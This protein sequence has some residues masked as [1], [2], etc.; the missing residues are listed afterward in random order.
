M[1]GRIDKRR[2]LI[3][4]ALILT[5]AGG[6]AIQFHVA[7]SGRNAETALPQ[8]GNETG[9]ARAIADPHAM[10]VQQRFE[11]AVALL[12]AGHFE[13]AIA[14]LREVLAIKPGLPEAHINMGYALLGMGNSSAAASHFETASDLRPS[15]YNAYYGL[16]LAE[17]DN[18]NETKALAAM[19]AFA[20]LADQGDRHLPRAQEFIWEL[21][22]SLQDASP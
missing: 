2:T 9:D 1:S 5:I 13:Y 14:A 7:D 6:A 16:A 10:H 11:D 18:G 8:A 22:K 4:V 20:H 3:P 12:Q 17:R 15:L 21:Q 19:Q